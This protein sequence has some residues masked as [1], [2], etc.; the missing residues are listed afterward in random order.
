[1]KTQLDPVK[2]L[3]PLI[4]SDYW[5]TLAEVLEQRKSNCIQQLLH[6]DGED[7]KNIQ[8]QVQ[9]LDHLLNLPAAIY[10]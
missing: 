3:R 6:C 8:G 5:D 7:L 1:M 9:E 4:K 2:A 10:R